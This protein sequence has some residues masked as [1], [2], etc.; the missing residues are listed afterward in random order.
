MNVVPRK[1][2]KPWGYEYIWAETK[3]YVGKILFIKAGYRLSLQ[4]H[5][6]KEET[7]VLESG[8]A[9]IILEDDDFNL[10]PNIM[11]KGIPFHIA[12][13]QIHRVEAIEDSIIY[14]VSTANLNDV[15]RHLDDYNRKIDIPS[16]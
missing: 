8:V 4:H 12:P 7:M 11:L 14:E 13:G 2:N 3:S 9:K 5:E 15:V 10:T 6:V 1:I 16:S